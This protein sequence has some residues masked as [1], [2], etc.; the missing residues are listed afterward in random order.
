MEPRGTFLEHAAHNLQ[1]P[2]V[3]EV[4]DAIEQ[5]SFLKREFNF[6]FGLRVRGLA[7]VK[8]ALLMKVAGWN[9][10]R[11]A[12][13][14]KRSEHLKKYGRKRLLSDILSGIQASILASI[15]VWKAIRPIYNKT[16]RW[17]PA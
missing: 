8:H 4:A 13:S 2:L 1:L 16:L 5:L 7:S 10:L 14:K 6:G 12:C 11:A 3:K 15:A 9:I 17:N